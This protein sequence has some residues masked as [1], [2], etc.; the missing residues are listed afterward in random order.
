MARL[1]ENRGLIPERCHQT[2]SGT[3]PLGIWGSFPGREADHSP[4]SSCEVKT[5]LSYKSSSQ[6]VPMARCFIKQSDK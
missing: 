4:P 6:Y 3:H 1:P 5:A 2:G